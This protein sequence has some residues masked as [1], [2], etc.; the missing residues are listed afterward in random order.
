MNKIAI[1]AI[2][3]V[4]FLAGGIIGNAD[5]VAEATNGNGNGVWAKMIARVS[6]LEQRVTTLEDAP[7]NKMMFKQLHDDVEGNAAGWTPDPNQFT[8][9]ITDSDVHS[10]SLLLISIGDSP[11][12]NVPICDASPFNGFFTIECTNASLLD[13][14]TLSYVITNSN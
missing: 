5:L 7:A 3:A 6:G 4:A 12:G 14:E 1:V 2:V 11:G 10:N 8:F 13:G 9:V